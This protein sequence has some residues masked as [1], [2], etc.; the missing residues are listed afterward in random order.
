MEWLFLTSHNYWIVCRLVRDN[1]CPFLA[2]SPIISIEDSSEP[3]RALLGAILS[4]LKGTHIEPSTFNPDMQLDTIIEET[5]D[6]P[7]PED[8]TDGHSGVNQ[9]RPSTGGA[10]KPPMTHSRAR[11]AGHGLMVCP[12]VGSHLFMVVSFCSQITSSSP[13][14]PESF[15]V[16]VHLQA[17]SNNTLALPVPGR[18]GQRRLW[19]TR[20]I[21]YGSTSAKQ[22]VTSQTRLVSSS[23]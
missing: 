18:N 16:W 2:Y 12:F 7:Q 22:N 10:T 14:S 21:G 23:T 8:D 11:V 17:L 9:G 19:L 1:A 3:F 6:G 4:V 15:Q 20:F 13:S 5:D